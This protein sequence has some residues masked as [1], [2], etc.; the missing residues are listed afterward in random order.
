MQQYNLI[1]CHLIS[2]Q[3]EHEQI[4]QLQ[5]VSTV[6]RCPLISVADPMVRNRV[7]NAD[8]NLKR[9]PSSYA[10]YCGDIA[11]KTVS[12]PPQKRLNG[13]TPVRNMKFYLKQW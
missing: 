12:Y 9:A 3:E 5:H 6:D 2:L 8:F 10:L 11:K 4:L 13:K 7:R 1:Q